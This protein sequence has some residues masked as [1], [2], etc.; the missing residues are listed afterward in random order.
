[1]SSAFRR[2]IQKLI[3]LLLADASSIDALRGIHHALRTFDRKRGSHAEQELTVG[4]DGIEAIARTRNT[5]ALDPV[6][7]M[8]GSGHRL[9]SAQWSGGVSSWGLSCPRT[10]SFDW[11]VSM[12]AVS[13]PRS[14][15]R[16]WWPG[17][18]ARSR[19]TTRRRA[20]RWCCP[21]SCIPSSPRPPSSDPRSAPVVFRPESIRGGGSKIPTIHALRLMNSV[22]AT[23]KYSEGVVTR[24][25]RDPI[26]ALLQRH[27]TR[28]RSSSGP[29]IDHLS[30]RI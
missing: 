19:R 13:T 20:T 9:P 7:Q 24:G 2:R 17:T 12:Q 8:L 4:Q 15:F 14:M 30:T 21:C 18:I 11:P 1:M 16:T 28:S 29:E 26:L 10:V 5:L 3:K 6:Q 27:P 25:A 22:Y 23:G